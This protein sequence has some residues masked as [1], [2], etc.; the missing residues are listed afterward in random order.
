[1]FKNDIIENRSIGLEDS[2]IVALKKMDIEKT[3]ILFVFSNDKFE[4]ILTIGD[5]QRAILNKN[6]LIRRQ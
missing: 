3:K 4:G 1:M 2:I 5:I 6:H